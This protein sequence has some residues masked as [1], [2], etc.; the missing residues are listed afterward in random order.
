M[1]ESKKIYRFLFVLVILLALA[2]ELVTMLRLGRVI[3]STFNLVMFY[4][5]LFLAFVIFFGSMGFLTGVVV[6][7]VYEKTGR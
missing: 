3:P 1:I 4:I 2:T 5:T 6:K 7:V